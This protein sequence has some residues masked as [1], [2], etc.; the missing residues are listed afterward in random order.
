VSDGEN[1]EVYASAQF[2]ISL[3]SW[4]VV[5]ETSCVG[6]QSEGPIAMASLAY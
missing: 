3:K 4:K 6:P 5:I 1:R 2:R